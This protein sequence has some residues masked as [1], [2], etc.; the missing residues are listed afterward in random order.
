MKKSSKTEELEV[1]SEITDDLLN[2]LAAVSA[3]RGDESAHQIAIILLRNVIAS[4][5]INTL[6]HPHKKPKES[7]NNATYRCFNEMKDDIQNAI[8]NGFEV[9]LSEFNP[10]VDPTYFC[11]IY[12][13]G[14]PINKLMS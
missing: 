8:S 11:E 7:V 5:V 2:Y 14:E 9:A 12:P 10:S 1:A 6:K 3:E 13:M 4:Y